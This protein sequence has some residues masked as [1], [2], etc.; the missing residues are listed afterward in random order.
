MSK[1]EKIGLCNIQHHDQ[2]Q[3]LFRF[4]E[5]GNIQP[6]EPVEGSPLQPWMGIKG[7]V[8]QK[9]HLEWNF[10]KDRL[11][12]PLKRVGGRG[13]NRWQQVSWDDALDEIAARLKEIKE[14]YGPEYVA[15]ATGLTNHQWD[16][17]RFANIFGSP[18]VDSV[19]ARV[20]SGLETWMNVL[21]Y[22]QPA[23][24]GPPNPRYCKLLVL[25]GNRPSDMFPIKWKSGMQVPKRI[26]IDPRWVRECEGADFWLQIRP[27]TDA[28]LAL[29]WMNVIINEGLYDHE[30]VEKW[31]YGFDK[32]RER[33]QEYSPGRVSDI[34]WVPEEKIVTS[35]RFYAQNS[36]AHIQWGSP[37]GNYGV[38]SDQTERARCCLRAITG[39][40]GNLGGNHFNTTHPLQVKMHEMELEHM[41]PQDQIKK[42]VGSERFR[43]MSWPGYYLLPEESKKA[44]RAFVNRGAPLV[45]MLRA[46]RTGEPYP[47]KGFMF[48]AANIMLTMSQTRHVYEALKKVDFF[49]CIDVVMTPTALLADYVLPATNWIECP[50]LGF[51]EAKNVL[52]TGERVL[53]KSV[54]GK[55]D[56]KDD[57]EIWRSLAVRLGQEEYWPWKTTEEM[58]DYRLAPYGMTFGE[59]STKKI[60]DV[61]PHKDR[62]YEKT[63]FQTRTGKVES[64]PRS[65]KGSASIPFLFS[66]SRTK[67]LCARRSLQRNTPI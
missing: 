38:N 23:H 32:L 61:E 67:A 53:P 52:Y 16:I 13:E 18:N 29:G 9:Y 35:A 15:F 28:A 54:P 39:N 12:Y 56:R 3:V 20:C 44:N 17:A 62:P 31:T 59:F 8:R 63:G 57:Y 60:F 43:A 46:M 66:R 33:V 1:R 48:G 58:L 36:P 45:A 5:E 22:G 6:G 64:I 37:P 34:T 14:K 41:L 65:W 47:I 51:L 21:T 55:Y 42:A 10:H 27:G 25:W 49:T 50:Q 2:C 30:F 40:V 24:Y 4:D 7:C 11:N 26:V 19:N